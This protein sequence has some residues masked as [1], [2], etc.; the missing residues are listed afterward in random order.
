MH[1]KRQRWHFSG[2]D[3]VSRHYADSQ[4]LMAYRETTVGISDLQLKFSEKYLQEYRVVRKDAD[5]A[6]QTKIQW[7]EFPSGIT[8]D[9]EEL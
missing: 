4:F 7:F 3:A 9:A 8:M 1:A 6:T 2:R 5:I